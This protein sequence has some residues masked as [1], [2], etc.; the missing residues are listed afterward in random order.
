LIAAADV[1]AG[2]R[3]GSRARCGRCRLLAEITCDDFPGERLIACRNPVL[4]AERARKRE[5]LL[6]A[7]ERLLAPVIA[8]RRGP[9]RRRGED[10][11][12]GR[13]G[14]PSEATGS[15]SDHAR[16]VACCSICWLCSTTTELVG[17]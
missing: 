8:L 10:R 16:Q 6:A 7:T 3:G 1:V 13:Q 4:A 5:D 11:G 9:A 12:R 15:G 2:Q 17:G 14:D